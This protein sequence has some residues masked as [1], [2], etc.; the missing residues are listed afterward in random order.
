M[1]DVIALREMGAD[2]VPE[3]FSGSA[4][5]LRPGSFRP[6]KTPQLLRCHRFDAKTRGR[7]SA[8]AGIRVEAGRAFLPR[9]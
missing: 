9:P 1:R 4:K 3:N 5:R 2:R 7:N 6:S 8:Q